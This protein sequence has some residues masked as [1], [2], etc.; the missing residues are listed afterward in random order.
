MIMV[1]MSCNKKK[2]C[3]KFINASIPKRILQFITSN[4]SDNNLLYKLF[5]CLTLFYNL[6]S[7]S[8]LNQ[9]EDNNYITI[10]NPIDIKLKYQLLNAINPHSVSS[11]N[12][13]SPSIGEEKTFEPSHDDNKDNPDLDDLPQKMNHKTTIDSLELE[14]IDENMIVDISEQEEQDDDDDT[15]IVEDIESTEDI[16]EH[17][18]V[19]DMEDNEQSDDSC[20]PPPFS[21]N[22]NIQHQHLEIVEDGSPTK[23]AQPPHAT[24]TSNSSPN[25]SAHHSPSL[26]PI[27]VIESIGDKVN[28]I[29]QKSHSAAETVDGSEMELV[30]DAIS[31]IQSTINNLQMTMDMKTPQMIKKYVSENHAPRYSGIEQQNMIDSEAARAVKFAFALYS[32]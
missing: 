8:T 30:L 27:Q 2:T 6:S 29:R 16:M 26:T 18:N 20:Q 32:V 31:D 19:N 28:F 12:S 7:K 5:E 11:Q 24:T 25:K 23:S 13:E 3:N 14:Q 1:L 21:P 17:H 4:K 22:N 15:E 9:L 10:I